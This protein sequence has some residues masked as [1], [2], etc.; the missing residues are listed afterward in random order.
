M[1]SKREPKTVPPT[2][3]I[4]RHRFER[5]SAVDG[6]KT[7]PRI[8]QIFAECD[9]QNLTPEQRREKLREIFQRKR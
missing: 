9:R 3:T 4:G 5:I 8:Q 1:D 2:F 7:S 6:I